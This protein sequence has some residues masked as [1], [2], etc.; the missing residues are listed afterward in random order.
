MRRTGRCAGACATATLPP[1][2]VLSSWTILFRQGRLSVSASLSPGGPNSCTWLESFPHE[3]EAK[4][5]K[6]P[7]ETAEADGEVCWG[8]CYGYAAAQVSTGVPRL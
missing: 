5:L 2:S 7:T 4:W 3:I 8:I 1:W 6:S